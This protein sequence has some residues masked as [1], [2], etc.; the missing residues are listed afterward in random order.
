MLSTSQA[1]ETSE[2]MSLWFL[3]TFEPGCRVQTRVVRPE[4]AMWGLHVR[5]PSDSQNN[6]KV[7]IFFLH[8]MYF[9]NRAITSDQVGGVEKGEHDL[10]ENGL[11]GQGGGLKLKKFSK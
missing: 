3:A 8:Q 10:Q 7:K 6:S 5:S 9:P 1:P 2:H 4:E 11:D